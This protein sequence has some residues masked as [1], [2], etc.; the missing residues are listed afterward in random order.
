MKINKSTFYYISILIFMFQPILEENIGF[1][2]YYD[3]ITVAILFFCAVVK[4]R[5]SK[6]SIRLLVYFAIL[7]LIGLLGNFIGGAEQS[8]FAILQDIIS[9]GK[10]VFFAFAAEKIRIPDKQKDILSDWL[11]FTVRA[12]F[13]LI[14]VCA[15]VSQFVNLGMTTE[16][17]FGIKS[18]KFLFPN[19]A[20][21]NTYYYLYMILFSVTLFKN[22]K[23]RKFSNLFLVLGLISW[24]LTMRTRALTFAILYLGLYIYIVYLQKNTGKVKF[25]WYHAIVALA[26]GVLLGWES[27]EK[28]FF[29]N[30]KV[31]RYLL[32]R[33]SFQIARDHFPIGTGY[34]TF[35][36][37]ASK[38]YYSDVYYKYRLASF[39]GL[40]P[41]KSTYITDQY[42]FGI[43]GQFGVVGTILMVMIIVNIFKSI[44]GIARTEKALQLGALTLFMTSI[45]ASITAATFI[46]ASIIPSIMVFYLLYKRTES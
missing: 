15:A 28:Y 19:P 21:L 37:E 24:S 27:I 17:R 10:I 34:A 11:S 25:K 3:E 22:G 43:I 20:G 16:V 31:A 38:I 7:T 26:G 9:N 2:K 45:F 40:S 41:N 42:W 39:W 18:F 44:W 13:L 12:L 4:L 14:F 36:T 32:S 30:D 35:G 5:F 1:F 8:S 6:R 23:I 29:E 46:Q 33:T